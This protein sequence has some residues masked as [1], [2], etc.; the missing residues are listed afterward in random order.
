M[1]IIRRDGDSENE[2]VQTSKRSTFPAQNVELLTIMLGNLILLV[3]YESTLLPKS[4]VLPRIV[5]VFDGIRQF[6]AQ[7]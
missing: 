6:S 2:I 1:E 7:R 3:L 4:G 5:G